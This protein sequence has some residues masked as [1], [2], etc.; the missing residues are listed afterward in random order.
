MP[1]FFTVILVGGLLAGVGYAAWLLSRDAN[2][3][4][5]KA[6]SP[7]QLGLN[8]L[9]AGDRE[10][11]LEAFAASVR[12][13]S[14]NVDAYIH[15][16]NLLREKG[17]AERALHLHRELTVRA[18]QTEAQR[19]AVREALVKDWIAL[20]R[21]Q[22]ALEEA[23]QLREMDRRN[24]HAL[25]LL[26]QAYEAAGDW[27]RA[28]DVRTEMTRASG[29]R[30]AEG[31][32]DYRAAVGEIFL[33]QEKLEEAKR[34]FKAALRLKRDHPVALLRLGDIY[35][36][37]KRPERAMLLWKALAAAHPAHSHLVLERLE[38]SY[39]E[40][41]RFGEMGHLYEELLQRNP[42][43]IRI[44]LALSRMHLKRGDLAEATRAVNEALEREPQSLES[45]LLLVEIY[46]R[47]GDAGRALDEV[48]SILRDLGT[49]E[50]P[51]CRQCGARLDEYWSRCPKCLA[52]LSTA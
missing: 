26:L 47:R 52:W 6:E 13:D 33:R 22:D 8:A 27:D 3:E 11:A 17:E 30:D 21:P 51:S 10:E 40:R 7:Y 34:H 4:P 38:V 25:K 36:E 37:T 42:Q 29:D 31:L 41:G 50:P 43:D 35:Y 14:D 5:A 23:R 20:G 19:R 32:A 44:L 28:L 49:V 45:R 46:R 16:G 1:E 2:V 12:Q 48:E 18:G 15:L 24:G 9:L 39:F